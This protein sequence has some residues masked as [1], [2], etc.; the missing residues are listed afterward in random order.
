MRLIEVRRD[1]K[2]DIRTMFSISAI[3]FNKI[4]HCFPAMQL[5]F[6][7]LF[8]S[9]ISY[10]HA[11][12]YN[13]HVFHSYPRAVHDSHPSNSYRDGSRSSKIPSSGNTRSIHL[14]HT[15]GSPT[16]RDN[17]ITE[18]SRST[19]RAG[20]V[21][22]I[23]SQDHSDL[24]ICGRLSEEGCCS[25]DGYMGRD[26]GTGSGC[27][28]CLE[29]VAIDVAGCAGAGEERRCDGKGGG[30]EGEEDVVGHFESA[31][32]DGLVC[33]KRGTC[34]EVRN[35]IWILA[36]GSVLRCCLKILGVW[37]LLLYLS[38]KIL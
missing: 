35:E 1:D 37:K 38:A 19:T 8:L 10:S 24:R 30:E 18:I 22:V 3:C 5:M 11:P 16:S 9:S 33:S 14:G 13:L 20:P 6:S 21:H 12:R 15:D 7:I 25:C 17:L 32:K 2:C 31:W 26:G 34:F 36:A 29:G 27:V 23:L 4:Y 28:G